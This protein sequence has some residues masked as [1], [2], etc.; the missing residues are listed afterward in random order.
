M[1]ISTDPVQALHTRVSVPLLQGPVP[2]Q[3]VLD[4]IFLAGLRAADHAALRPWRFLVIR[5]EARQSLGELFASAALEDNPSEGPDKL[6]RIKA[7]PLRAPL[8]VVAIARVIEHPK[9]PELEQLLSTGAA[10]QNML[11]AAH[12]KGLGSIW[13]TGAMAG[14]SQVRKGLG[15][16]S[17]EHIIGFL[18]LGYSAG[19]VKPVPQ[20]KVADYF[21]EWSPEAE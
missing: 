13:R 10:V 11:N 21:T 20:L 4:D 8:I 6:N 7:K 2:P 5:D 14:H 18:Y 9:V 12:M 17:N 16:S 3:E 15:V 19:K 1:S